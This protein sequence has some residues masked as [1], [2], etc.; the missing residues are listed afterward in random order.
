MASY[1]TIPDMVEAE[2]LHSVSPSSDGLSFGV[3]IETGD[4]AVQLMRANAEGQHIPLVVL[5]TD[6][7]MLALDD[8]FVSEV[9]TSSGPSPS[10]YVVFAATAV[11]FV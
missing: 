6:V 2:P 4:T 8:V 11:R 5:T 9:S 1:L 3:V 7:Q 10:T